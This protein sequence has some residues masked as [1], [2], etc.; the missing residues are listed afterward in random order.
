MRGRRRKAIAGSVLITTATLLGIP[1]RAAD[2]DVS[3]NIKNMCTPD[4]RRL[5][6]QHPLGSEQM[7]YCMEAKFSNI[8]RDCV[9]ALE[10][11]GMVSAGTHKQH[12]NRR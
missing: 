1:V 4:A 9:K 7:R 11:E 12:A 6:P 8:S 3:Q 2:E 10:D 5:C